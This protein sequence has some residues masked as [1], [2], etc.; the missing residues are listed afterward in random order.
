VKIRGAAPFVVL[1]TALSPRVLMYVGDV[2]LLGSFPFVEEDRLT[3]RARRPCDAFV[4]TWIAE[5][6]YW[7]SRARLEARIE[8][9]V[10]GR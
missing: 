9:H 7:D 3:G 5:L 2:E 8:I 6:R 1:F 10:T 4:A